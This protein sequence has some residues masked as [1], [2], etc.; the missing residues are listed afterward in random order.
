MLPETTVILKVS[1][2]VWFFFTS[3]VCVPTGKITLKKA[4][5]LA[6][7]ELGKGYISKKAQLFCTTVGLYPDI[8]LIGP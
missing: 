4:Y 5:P 1:T 6:V 2:T 8:N 7:T 3:K